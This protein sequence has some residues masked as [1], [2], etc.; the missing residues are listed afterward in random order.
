MQKYP[1]K[2]YS[3]L[4]LL[5]HTNTFMTD[6]FKIQVYSKI[7]STQYANTQ[8]NVTTFKVNGI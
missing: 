1:L 7:Y 6:R 4:H 5:S 8:N 3:Y 2:H